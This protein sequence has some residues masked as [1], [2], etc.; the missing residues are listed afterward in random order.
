MS[1]DS[2]RSGDPWHGRARWN[3]LAGGEVAT[4]VTGM[5]ERIQTRRGF[6]DEPHD[7]VDDRFQRF[8]RDNFTQTAR[9]ARLLTNRPDVAD[10]LAHDCSNSSVNSTSHTRPI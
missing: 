2:Y 6:M 4:D 3:Q 7:H 8:Y 1:Q 10:D 5:I 9:L